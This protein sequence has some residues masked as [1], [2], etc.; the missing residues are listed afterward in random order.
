MNTWPPQASYP[1][2][3]FSDTSFF[4]VQNLITSASY[5]EGYFG[6]NQLL[7][8][9]ISLSPQ[10]PAPAIDLTES[11]YYPQSGFSLTSIWPGIVPLGLSLRVRY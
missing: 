3:N 5:W 4:K 1:F 8:G 7:D 2:G 9:L 6:R 10:N 11:R